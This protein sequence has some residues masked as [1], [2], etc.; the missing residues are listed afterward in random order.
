MVQYFYLA[1]NSVW[2]HMFDSSQENIPQTSHGI[3]PINLVPGAVSEVRVDN[4]ANTPDQKGKTKAR[5]KAKVE[6][7][8]DYIVYGKRKRLASQRLLEAEGKSPTTGPVNQ[9]LG[10]TSPSKR[11]RRRAGPASQQKK[12]SGR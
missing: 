8:E 4:S 7:P 9:S 12:K 6:N 5:R 2:Q 11:K 3:G 10:Q 1:D